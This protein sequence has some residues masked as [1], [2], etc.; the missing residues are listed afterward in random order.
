MARGAG[1]PFGDR[2]RQ[3]RLPGAARPE[4]RQQPG[5]AELAGHLGQLVL[6]TDEAGQPG[7]Q[8]RARGPGRAVGARRGR[9]QQGAVGGAQ[10]QRVREHAHGERAR[11]GT[12]APLQRGD[13]VRAQPGPLGQRLLR[14]PGATRNRRSAAPNPV[15][16][17]SPR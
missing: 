4:K 3:R 16:G 15:P 17:A 12:P 6:A 10:R 11:P 2:D 1:L 8:R 9:R 14:Q 13:G 5:L 7:R